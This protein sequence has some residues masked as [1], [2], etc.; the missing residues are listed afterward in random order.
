[1]RWL[2]E[3]E[4]E[5]ERTHV[6]GGGIIWLCWTDGTATFLELWTDKQVNRTVEDGTDKSR[7]CCNKIELTTSSMRHILSC[8]IGIALRII[9]HKRESIGPW[10]SILLFPRQGRQEW[11]L[12]RLCPIGKWRKVWLDEGK[13]P[14]TPEVTWKKQSPA[15]VRGSIHL[16]QSKFS[17]ATETDLG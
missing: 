1:M 11:F 9:I 14:P 10:D 8:L 3:R 17:V 16:L 5:R 15:T 12:L 6:G 2:T 7:L 13:D 4:R